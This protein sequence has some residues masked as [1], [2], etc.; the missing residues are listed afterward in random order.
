MH[1]HLWYGLLYLLLAGAFARAAEPVITLSCGG[2]VKATIGSDEGQRKPINKVELLV[3]LAEHKVL[4]AGYVAHIEDVDGMN[5][6][7]GSNEDAAT[8]DING[9]SGL[10][11]ATT[12]SGNVRTSY[13]LFCKRVTPSNSRKTK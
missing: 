12:V 2:T 4:F 6:F 9:D 8:G 7:F 5:V 10:M 3:D 11:P 1:R 13:E